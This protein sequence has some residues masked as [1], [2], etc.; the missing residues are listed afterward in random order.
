ME[1]KIDQ[2]ITLSS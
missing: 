1:E 2:V